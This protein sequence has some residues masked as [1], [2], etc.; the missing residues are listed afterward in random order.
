MEYEGRMIWGVGK[1]GVIQGRDMKGQK[2]CKG[3]KK[4]EMEHKMHSLRY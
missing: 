1:N 3:K 2:K 4:S